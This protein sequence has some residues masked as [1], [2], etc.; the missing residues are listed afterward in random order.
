TITTD[1]T[2]ADREILHNVTPWGGAL[3]KGRWKLVHNG[4]VPANATQ[5][6][7]TDRFEL[8]DV[9]A[10]PSEQ[11]DRSDEEPKIVAAMRARLEELRA[12]AVPPILS[13]N[14]APKGFAVPKVWGEGQ[15]P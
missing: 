13:P 15:K 9:L 1:A 6:P 4:A 12:A 7:P 11:Q 14:A 3:R 8:F 10:D 2:A 5:A